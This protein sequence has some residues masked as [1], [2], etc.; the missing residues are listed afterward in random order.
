MQSSV[1]STTLPPDN[2]YCCIVI[3]DKSVLEEGVDDDELS[4]KF[5]STYIVTHT[6]GAGSN[7]VIM[8][9]FVYHE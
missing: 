9:V 5:S 3:R 7:F 1:N 4:V 2:L 6:I 8:N